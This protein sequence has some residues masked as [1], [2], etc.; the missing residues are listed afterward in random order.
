[1]VKC[2]VLQIPAVI[3]QGKVSKDKKRG[4]KQEVNLNGN[5]NAIEGT[6]KLVLYLFSH[7]RQ[8]FGGLVSLHLQWG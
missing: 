3:T 5:G 4:E 7:R 6:A 2:V 8:V 1:M